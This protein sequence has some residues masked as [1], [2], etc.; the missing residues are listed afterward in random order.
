MSLRKCTNCDHVT[1]RANKPKR[2][3][4]CGESGKQFGKI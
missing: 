3:I 2:C 1:F 4:I